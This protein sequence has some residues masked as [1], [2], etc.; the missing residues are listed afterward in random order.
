MKLNQGPIS[1]E[2]LMESLAKAKGVMNKVDGGNYTKGNITQEMLEEDNEK[3]LPIM[4][5]QPTTNPNLH[6]TPDP[7]TEDKVNQ[8]R[9]PDNIKKAMLENPINQIG[10]DST[11]DMNFVENTKQLMNESR[12]TN[13]TPQVPQQRQTYTETP[14]KKSTV[15][16]SEL[17]RRLTPIIENIIR[18][19]MDE[20][21][22][23]KLN[24]ILSASQTQTINEGLAIKVGETIFTGKLTKAKS[25]K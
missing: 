8:S 4:E 24:Q 17:E 23:R 25:I 5:N 21:V 10:L 1:K 14:Q 16:S 11:L 7:I 2:G 13:K 22:D 6:K 20:I 9:L 19:T 3:P 18:K 15:S 12:S